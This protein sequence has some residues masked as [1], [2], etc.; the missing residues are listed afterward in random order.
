MIF[1]SIIL[2]FILIMVGLTLYDSFQLKKLEKEHAI[3]S[4]QYQMVMEEYYFLISEEGQQAMLEVESLCNT[5]GIALD[6]EEEEEE[7]DDLS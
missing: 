3:V 7:E 5:L 1:Y 4:R 6:R 2:L